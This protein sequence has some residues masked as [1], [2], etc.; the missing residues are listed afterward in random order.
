MTTAQLTQTVV[1]KGVWG[2]REVSQ[3]MGVSLRV[4]QMVLVDLEAQYELRPVR[5][6]RRRYYLKADFLAALQRKR[7]RDVL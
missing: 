2:T 3:F 4:A 6:E 5:G 1:E 7:D